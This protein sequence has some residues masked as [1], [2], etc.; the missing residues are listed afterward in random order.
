MKFELKSMVRMSLLAALICVSSYISFSIGTVPISA[1]TLVI[2]IVGL[3]LNP[4]EAGVTVGIYILLGAIGL[5]VYSNG[6]S[7]LG[8]LFGPTGGYIWGFLIGAVAI[9]HIKNLN[10]SILNYAIACFIGGILIIYAMGAAGLMIVAKMSLD[11]ALLVG[12]YPFLIGDIAKIVVAIII[13]NRIEKQ[14]GSI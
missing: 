4:K 10:K 9:S 5:P 7:G 2:M 14:I 6:S 12:V 1:Q 13:V 3:M 8:I 11:K